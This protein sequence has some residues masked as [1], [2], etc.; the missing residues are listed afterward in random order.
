MIILKFNVL[1]LNFAS[2]WRIDSLLNLIITN[3]KSTFNSL[4]VTKKYLT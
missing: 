3:I 4:K 1:I 2:K